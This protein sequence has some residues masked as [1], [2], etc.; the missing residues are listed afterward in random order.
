MSILKWMDV[1]S[2]LSIKDE[3]DRLF[4]KMF[5]ST[6]FHS[7]EERYALVSSGTYTPQLNAFYRSDSFVIQSRMPEFEKGDI[8]ISISGNLLAIG[9]EVNRE[10]EFIGNNAYRYHKS[11]GSFCKVLELP[12]GL[13]TNNARSTFRNGILEIVIPRSANKSIDIK[14]DAIPIETGKNEPNVPILRTTEQNTFPI[15]KD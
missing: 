5:E 13:D 3:V 7:W 8:K 15:I 4:D 12:T 11:Y 2:L 10:R 14:E 6:K 9:S 1:N